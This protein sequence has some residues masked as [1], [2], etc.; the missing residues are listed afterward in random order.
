MGLRIGIRNLHVMTDCWM[1]HL[2]LQERPGPDCWADRLRKRGNRNKDRRT[3]RTAEGNEGL[4]QLTQGQ[5]YVT[6]STSKETD[7]LCG[8]MR[9]EGGE[10]E[11]GR[12]CNRLISSAIWSYFKY[13]KGFTMMQTV[14]EEDHAPG[15]LH[16]GAGCG[17]QW[18]H[19]RRHSTYVA[20]LSPLLHTST[21]SQDP[22]L[23]Q[24]FRMCW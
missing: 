10:A 9:R 20:I 22:G 24:G 13:W 17:H 8:K 1:S 21:I 23:R 18:G 2:S 5:R 3:L 4:R 19:V 15:T 7:D 11:A 14:C 16:D 12:Q 6:D